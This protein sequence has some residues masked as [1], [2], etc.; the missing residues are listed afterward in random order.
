MQG[1][2]IHRRYR[3]AAHIRIRNQCRSPI[4]T[5]RPEKFQREGGPEPQGRGRRGQE[6]QRFGWRWHWKWLRLCHH[7]QR[8]HSQAWRPP[9]PPPPCTSPRRPRPSRPGQRSQTA[10]TSSLQGWIWKNGECRLQGLGD[11]PFTQRPRRWRKPHKRMAGASL[12]TACKTFILIEVLQRQATKQCRNLVLIE[13]ALF[14]R[15]FARH[16]G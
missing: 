8:R 15:R 13:A 10:A 14:R 11:A 6:W 9:P 12:A 3:Q 1:H 5:D 4:R 2:R 7:C 16:A